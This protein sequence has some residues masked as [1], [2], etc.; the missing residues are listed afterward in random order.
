MGHSLF[1]E[2]GKNSSNTRLSIPGCWCQH[3]HCIHN[4][5][6]KS[7]KRS[8]L[9]HQCHLQQRKMGA[10]FLSLKALDLK[11]IVYYL[12]QLGFKP[13]IYLIVPSI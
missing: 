8:H 11:M 1:K 2:G 6:S 3:V 4:P 5:L 7:Q 9:S 10:I 13:K 12:F